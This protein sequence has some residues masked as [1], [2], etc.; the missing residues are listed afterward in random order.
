M[1]NLPVANVQH[2][3][4]L[5]TFSMLIQRKGLTL[6]GLVIVHELLVAELAAESS[7]VV[8]AQREQVLAEVIDALVAETT[9]PRSYWTDRTAVDIPDDLGDVV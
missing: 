8:A 5:D 3:V 7:P 6:D 4:E 2:L 1:P 9:F